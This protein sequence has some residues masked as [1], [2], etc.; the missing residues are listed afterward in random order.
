M[1]EEEEEDREEEEEE[2]CIHAFAKGIFAKGNVAWNLI[3]VRR[4]RFKKV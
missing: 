2:K 1:E 4:F 3:S